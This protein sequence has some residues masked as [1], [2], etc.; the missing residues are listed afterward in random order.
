ME[1]QNTLMGRIR[2]NWLFILIAAQ[3]VLDVLAYWTNN[4]HSSWAGYIR[5]VIMIALPVVMLI[6]LDK[7][8]H[9]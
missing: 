5:L 6:R 9:F 8:K 7:K 1:K 3:P 2:D 4:T